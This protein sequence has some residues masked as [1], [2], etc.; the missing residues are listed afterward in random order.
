MEEL[1]FKDK[2]CELYADTLAICPKFGRFLTKAFNI[3]FPHRDRIYLTRYWEA[4]KNNENITTLPKSDGLLR[5]IQLTNL[6]ILKEFDFVCR[7]NGLNYWLTYGTSLGAKRHNGYIPWDD[8]I[9]VGMMRDD[10]E[11]FQKIFDKSTRNKDLYV[12]I[13]KNKHT[14]A[15]LL[16]K[17]KHKCLPFAFI[18]IFSYEYVSHSNTSEEREEKNK[19]LVELRKNIDKEKSLLKK[20]IKEI[21]QYLQNLFN[22]NICENSVPDKNNA[23]IAIGIDFPCG[24]PIRLFSHDTI[25]PLKDIDFEGFSLKSV[26]NPEIFL[27]GMFGKSYMDYPP[28]ISLGHI[29]GQIITKKE[30]KIMDELIKT[31]ND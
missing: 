10:Y 2:L 24:D 29:S 5:K 11:K 21:Q 27:E 28:E 25:F 31:L 4:Q 1:T 26:N 8:D 13:I 12:E 23:D 16:L 14:P 6:A 3:K 9:D 22:E 17:I 7:T 19:K 15:M 18:D 20:N 30:Q